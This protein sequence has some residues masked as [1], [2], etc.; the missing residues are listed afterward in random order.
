M[1]LL[2]YRAFSAELMKIA[3]EVRDAEI[4]AVIAEGLGKPDST[5][6]LTNDP[7]QTNFKPKLAGFF[8]SALK[9]KDYD[10]HKHKSLEQT[11]Y[12]LSLEEWQRASPA[13]R[14]RLTGK[15]GKKPRPE[16]FGLDK[17]AG[18]MGYTPQSAYNFRGK[19]PTGQGSPYETGSNFA[20]TALKGGMTGAGVATL[21]HTLRHGH[22]L[23]IAP[24]HLG[25]AVAIGSGV[26]LADRAFRRHSV[27]KQ[28]Q[29][30]KVAMFSPARELHAT[31]TQGSFEPKVHHTPLKPMAG[32]IGRPTGA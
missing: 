22:D 24:K 29:K 11:E 1:N 17:V 9:G 21:G 13:H 19:A 5:Y 3:T 28:Q 8:G 15:G 14:Q 23:R 16:E 25:A 26:A 4:R 27:L 2:G 7:T 12:E 31:Q 18:F 30:Q 10:Q 6:P 20:S 32:I